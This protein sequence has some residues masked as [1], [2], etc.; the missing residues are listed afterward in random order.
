V[1]NNYVLDITR[2]CSLISRNAKI[3]T[4]HAFKWDSH[5]PY[6]CSAQLT[7]IRSLF[8]K[9]LFDMAFVSIPVR[10]CFDKFYNI[11]N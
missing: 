2:L 11:I 4:R 9:W 3:G 1:H 6:I 8:T 10:R 5:R 7:L